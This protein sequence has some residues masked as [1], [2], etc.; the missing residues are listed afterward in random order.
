M[1]LGLQ[2]KCHSF[3]YTPEELERIAESLADPTWNSDE[4]EWRRTLGNVTKETVEDGKQ[5][6]IAAELQ[7]LA[8]NC[9]TRL[10]GFGKD[11]LKE[12]LKTTNRLFNQVDRLLEL[13]DASSIYRRTQKDALLDLSELQFD[14]NYK[15]LVVY[16]E[17]QLLSKGRKQVL[18]NVRNAYKDRPK[19]SKQPELM[20]LVR[21]LMLFWEFWTGEEAGGSK[22]GG[23]AARFVMYSIVPVETYAKEVLGQGLRQ[24]KAGPITETVAGDLIH[25]GKKKE[26]GQ[27]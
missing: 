1:T 19:Y 26:R 23:P 7:P 9:L 2:D 4:D 14:V 15:E 17:L 13:L 10:C 12:E 8:V 11:P 20:E 21:Q 24:A 6:A 27:K 16:R 18:E 25:Q 5:A 3:T 22:E